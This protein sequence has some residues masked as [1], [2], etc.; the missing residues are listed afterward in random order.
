MRNR[1]VLTF[2]ALIVTAIFSAAAMA[3]THNVRSLNNGGRKLVDPDNGCN[4]STFAKFRMITSW[5]EPTPGYAAQ[6]H[7]RGAAL[8]DEEDPC[9]PGNFYE[10]SLNA[11]TATSGSTITGTWD[12]YRNSIL[13]CSACTGVASGLNQTAG[14]GNHY[15]VIVD[16]P[17][18]GPGTWIYS[19]YIDQRDDF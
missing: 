9:V 18:Y 16:D 1:I 3:G 7:F 19:G 11:S 4:Y 2:F 5:T 17:V 12:I 15:N 14:V 6:A 13:M 8:I 10:F